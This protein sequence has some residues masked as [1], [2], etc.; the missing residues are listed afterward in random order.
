VIIW[1]EKFIINSH[2]YVS[3]S[4]LALELRLDRTTVVR[5]LKPLEERDLIIDVAARA[6]AELVLNDDL[7]T[8]YLKQG[9][10][11]LNVICI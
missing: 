2:Q 5:N 10:I 6:F 8:L 1:K 4:S 11:R 3:V 9:M 7:S